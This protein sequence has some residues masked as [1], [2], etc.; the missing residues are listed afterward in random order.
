MIKKL[1]KNKFKKMSSSQNPVILSHSEYIGDVVSSSSAS[2][3]ANAVIGTSN[4][5]YPQLQINAGNSITFPW[6]ANIANHFI[7][8]EFDELIFEFQSTSATALNSTNTQLGIILCRTEVDPALP[9]DGN[10]SQLLNTN[11]HRKRMPYESF[12]VTFPKFGRKL[13]RTTTGT[14]SNNWGLATNRDIR[15]YDGGWFNIATSGMQATSVNLGQCHVHY[16]VRLYRPY[17]NLIAI[18]SSIASFGRIYSSGSAPTIS[19]PFNGTWTNYQSTSTNTPGFSHTTTT[20]TFPTT[21]VGAYWRVSYL[22]EGTAGAV[23][24]SSTGTLVG[25]TA[26]SSVGPNAWTSTGTTVSTGMIQTTY[27]QTSPTA[28]CDASTWLAAAPSSVTVARLVITQINPSI[29]A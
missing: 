29:I 2:T 7:H 11:G 6:L 5:T 8:Y 12:A 3:F 28:T 25:L 21:S 19:F 1:L 18:P 27:Q 10:M 22:I 17:L 23:T 9:I 24:F 20:I 16:K 26:V 4:S 14:T 13:I 15:N